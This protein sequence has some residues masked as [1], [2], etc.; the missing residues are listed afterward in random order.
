MEFV[1]CAET[2]CP[3]R[4]VGRAVPIARMAAKPALGGAGVV[5]STSRKTAVQAGQYLPEVLSQVGQLLGELVQ[6]RIGR[7]AAS[8]A[9]A[10]TAAHPVVRLCQ[11]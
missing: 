6:R 7:R 1:I 2:E 4:L 8:S 3:T 10:A 9:Q 11:V 5:G